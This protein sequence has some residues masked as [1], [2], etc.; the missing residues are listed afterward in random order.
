MEQLEEIYA[1]LEKMDAA[2]NVEVDLA[3]VNDID[4]YNGII[5]KGYLKDLPG[6]RFGRRS[7]RQGHGTLRQEGG[8]LGLCLY[9]NEIARLGQKKEEPEDDM[10]TIALPRE[11]WAIRFMIY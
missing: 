11:D 5:F 9:L 2:Q 1:G 4:Y 10:L 8:R 3:M 7:V 6:K